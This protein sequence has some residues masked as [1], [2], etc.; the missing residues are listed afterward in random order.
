MVNTRLE[1]IQVSLKFYDLTTTWL[2]TQPGAIRLVN[3][4]QVGTLIR[5]NLKTSKNFQW[6]QIK[7]QLGEV[8]H[9]FEI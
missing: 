5:Q 2:R 3:E 1:L 8:V 7:I 4:C 9:F 6:A